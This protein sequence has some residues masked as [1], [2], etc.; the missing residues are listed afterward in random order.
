M[1]GCRKKSSDDQIEPEEQNTRNS[2]IFSLNFKTKFAEFVDVLRRGANNTIWIAHSGSKT[3]ASSLSGLLENRNMSGEIV[4]GRQIDLQDK[5]V[6]D[7]FVRDDGNLI[8]AVSTTANSEFKELLLSLM[9][10][11][12][13]GKLIRERKLQDFSFKNP[14]GYKCNFET[15]EKGFLTKHSFSLATF[16][17][18]TLLL[19]Y[20]C[21]YSR[22]TLL[23][24][25]LEVVWSKDITGQLTDPLRAYGST[26]LVVTDEGTIVAMNKINQDDLGAFNLKYSTRLNAYGETNILVQ[27]FDMNGGQLQ[28]AV[29]GTKIHDSF[30]T[31]TLQK[32]ELYIVANTQV[33]RA[34]SAKDTQGDILITA[35]KLPGLTQ[36]WQKTLDVQDEDFAR[37]STII[38]GKYLAV[39]GVT[40]FLQVQTGS[41]T[42]YGDAF[43]LLTDLKGT[44]LSRKIFGTP[45]H[46]SVT[47]ILDLGSE[48]IMVGGYKDGPITHDG[49]T[50]KTQLHSYGFVEIF[51]LKD[52]FKK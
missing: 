23:S 44:E 12:A 16:K 7:F 35:L 49:D 38:D 10:F 18:K 4:E 6:A 26:G 48:N 46:D 8:A 30:A 24:E 52:I 21:F 41:L 31:A 28:T 20:N 37:S 11:D 25:S 50:D 32:D 17:S 9:L 33:A 27:N 39:G 43:M 2:S 42:K 22:L 36:I 14:D 34:T 5:S 15:V 51:T 1:S 29:V 47:S 3:F 40:G 13:S 45:R 19:T